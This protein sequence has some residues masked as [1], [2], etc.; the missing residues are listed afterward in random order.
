MESGNLKGF[1]YFQQ[2]C[3][4]QIKVSLYGGDSLFFK[5]FFLTVIEPLSIDFI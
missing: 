1:I 3:N 5:V 2:N 4:Q